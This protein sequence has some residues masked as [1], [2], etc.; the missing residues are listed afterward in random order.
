MR[1]RKFSETQSSPVG[2]SVLP[3]LA[4]QGLWPPLFQLAK[5][6]IANR[7]EELNSIF[8]AGEKNVVFAYKEK[9]WSL[10]PLLTNF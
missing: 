5:S 2:D 8:P 3:I 7:I 4:Y 10:L 6:Y 1:K 9:P